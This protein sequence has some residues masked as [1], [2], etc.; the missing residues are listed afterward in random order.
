MLLV[1]AER[2]A[3]FATFPDKILKDQCVLIESHCACFVKQT[4][5][6]FGFKIDC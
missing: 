1:R 4:D 2:L 6:D 5:T 3:N